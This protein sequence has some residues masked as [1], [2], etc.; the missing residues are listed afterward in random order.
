ML[1]D[2]FLHIKSSSVI[3]EN[4]LIRYIGSK[5]MFFLSGRQ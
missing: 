1:L 5:E 3:N 4:K 2:F